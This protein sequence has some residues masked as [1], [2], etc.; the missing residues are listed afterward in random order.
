M[1]AYRP[2]NCENMVIFGTNLTLMKNSGSPQKKLNIAAHAT[3]N[4]PVC[5]DTITVVKITLLHSVSVITN[6]VIPK[7]D[8]QTDRPK[9]SHFFVYSRRATHGP[10][11][12][13]IL[14]MVIEE[15]RAI[16]AHP[17]PRNLAPSPNF[18]FIGATRRSCGAKNLFL[19]HSVKTIPAWLR[20]AQACRW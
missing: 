2:Q 12:P 13:T 1:W 7:R 16:F 10:T 20:F 5:N 6:C 15:V 3:R 4:L 11:I 14:G 18:M 9:T 19:D 8:K 17:P